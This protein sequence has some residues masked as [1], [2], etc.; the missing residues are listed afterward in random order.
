MG[1]STAR[2]PRMK[3]VVVLSMKEV[4]E[5]L[6]F[7]PVVEWVVVGCQ[8]ERHDMSEK[9]E[10]EGLSHCNKQRAL[11]PLKRLIRILV[12]WQLLLWLN[13]MAF[14]YINL[15]ASGKMI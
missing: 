4:S 10:S 1:I 15:I 14:H 9:S 3:I 12:P 13:L 2:K 8:E 5:W 7:I 6:Y 11:N